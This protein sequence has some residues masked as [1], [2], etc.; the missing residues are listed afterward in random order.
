MT[1]VEIPA[2]LAD[3][4]ADWI[5]AGLRVE[6][7]AERDRGGP[8]LPAG[9]YVDLV[10]ALR[11]AATSAGGSDRWTDP[12]ASESTAEVAARLGYSPRWVRHLARV[13]ALPAHRT[14]RG[15]WQ[16]DTEVMTYAQSRPQ[17]CRRPRRG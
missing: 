12:P 5:L 2:A 3:R 1:T 8:P 11:R 7:A 16:F 15:D 14:H 4:V 17:R 13:G 9:L 6:L 10:R